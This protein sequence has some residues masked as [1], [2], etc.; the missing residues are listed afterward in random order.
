[1]KPV[2]RC[3]RFS[4]RRKGASNQA[5]VLVEFVVG[6]ARFADKVPRRF[7]LSIRGTE[8]KGY[9]GDETNR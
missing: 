2:D 3:N 4:C 5:L 6:K 8:W 7:L 1:M 9:A